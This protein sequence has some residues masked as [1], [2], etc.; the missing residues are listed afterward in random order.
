[1]FYMEVYVRENLIFSFSYLINRRKK[2]REYTLFCDSRITFLPKL[3]TSPRSPQLEKRWCNNKRPS[4]AKNKWIIFLKRPTSQISK[5][6]KE[7]ERGRKEG[8]RRKKEGRK[9]KTKEE[10]KRWEGWR[11]GKAICTV[12]PFCKIE[13]TD[14][15]WEC[16]C[17]EVAKG[18]VKKKKQQ[19][20]TWYQIFTFFCWRIIFYKAKSYC[21]TNIK[22][23]STK[24][25]T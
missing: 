3:E 23:T 7:R 1:M 15:I 10:G 12:I 6:K 25:F 8:K 4:T 2:V 5:Y 19:Y 16:I 9:G 24:I 18:I 22:W 17:R 21:H 11:K 14:F 13:Y 20:L